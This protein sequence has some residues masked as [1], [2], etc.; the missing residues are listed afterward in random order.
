MISLNHL[1]PR[2][3]LPKPTHDSVRVGKFAFPHNKD[4]PAGGVK[5][6]AISDIPAPVPLDFGPPV[7]RVGLGP[8]GPTAVR[9]P[10]PKA[11]MD[12][13]RFPGAEKSDVGFA[14]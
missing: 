6:F 7:A 4:V 13:N 14:R 5:S 3:E 2:Q 11:S 9:V 8:S 1:F 10:V 12:K